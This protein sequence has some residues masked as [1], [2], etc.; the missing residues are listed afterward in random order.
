MIVPEPNETAQY[1]GAS[2]ERTVRRGGSTHDNVVAA[3]GS[4][5]SAIDLK[6]F[7]SQS[8]LPGVGVHVFGLLNQFVP[9]GCGM[10]V[11]FDHARVGRHLD[12][13]QSLVVWWQV[14]FQDDGRVGGF[15]SRFDMRDQVQIVFQR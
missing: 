1:V 11:D 12:H 10:D 2:E 7:G 8:R 3:A 4:R 15:G 9:A 5:V 13:F 6:L 14:A